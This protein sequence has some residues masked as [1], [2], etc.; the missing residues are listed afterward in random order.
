MIDGTNFITRLQNIR[1]FLGS[2]KYFMKTVRIKVL[3]IPAALKRQSPTRGLD[4][5]IPRGPRSN[6]ERLI[7]CLRIL[8]G[9]RVVAICAQTSL[10][11]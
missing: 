2:I 9:E 8:R 11:H 5:D 1:F 6:V 7:R 3:V 10:R 4:V